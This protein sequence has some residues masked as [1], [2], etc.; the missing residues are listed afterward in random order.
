MNNGMANS[1]PVVVDSIVFKVNASHA[2]LTLTSM[3]DPVLVILVSI[4][5]A[6]NATNAIKVAANVQ[7]PIAISV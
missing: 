2:K 6:I 3:G 7:A 5:W 4:M 1:A